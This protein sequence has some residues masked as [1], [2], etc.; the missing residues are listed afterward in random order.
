MKTQVNNLIL[1]SIG[2]LWNYSAH[3]QESI[4]GTISNYTAGGGSIVS[5]DMISKGTM[6]IG[7]I[8]Q[9]G[10]FRIPLDENYLATIKKKAESTKQAEDWE[11]EFKTVATAF[12]C[13]GLSV[14][15]ENGETQVAGIPELQ[16]TLK[17][18]EWDESVLFAV[19][20]P[21]IAN[22]LYSYG[23]KNAALGYYVQWFFAEEQASAI[24]NC[25]WETSVSTG[26]IYNN[27]TILE[28]K[29][30]KGWNIIKYSITEVF[31]D[32]NG[33]VTP[34]KTELSRI[35]NIP[36]DIQWVVVK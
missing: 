29:L 33:K 23:E 18:E 15:Y 35:D 34:S 14:D 7:T 17:D 25:V 2:I 32:T 30:Q 16:V 21:E 1:I 36:E 5:Y 10:H 28:V 6:E 19:S 13:S 26:E 22:W 8:D 27:V 11:I 4:E 9:E 12:E 24:A 31:T 20:T 3:T